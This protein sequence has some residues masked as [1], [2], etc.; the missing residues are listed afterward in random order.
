[1]EAMVDHFV[2]AHEVDPSIPRPSPKS[3]AHVIGLGRFAMEHWLGSHPSMLPC[4]IY[5]GVYEWGYDELPDSETPWV[6]DLKTAPR[7]PFNN[8]TKG[9]QYLKNHKNKEWFCGPARLLEYGFLYNNE[10]PPPQSYIWTMYD[11]SNRICP[12]PI[13]PSHVWMLHS[14][15]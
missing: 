8:T 5:P 6:P 3:P 4:D 1:M 14:L 7:V 11:E 13:N 9:L 15:V 10:L 12:V 2:K